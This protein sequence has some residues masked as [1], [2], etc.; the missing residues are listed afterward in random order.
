MNLVCLLCVCSV[1][2]N[3]YSFVS[4]TYVNSYIAD[5]IG[6]SNGSTSILKAHRE[7]QDALDAVCDL[8]DFCL[9]A[10]KGIKEGWPINNLRALTHNDVQESSF[11]RSLKFDGYKIAMEIVAQARRVSGTSLTSFV[12]LV[13]NKT[14]PLNHC[15]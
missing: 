11:M 14:S 8:Y 2:Y 3:I 15:S 4:N 7:M 13:C 10:K 1:V 12:L 6:D 5:K 9:W